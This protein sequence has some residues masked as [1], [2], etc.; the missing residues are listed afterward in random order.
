MKNGI[1]TGALCLFSL[2]I[3]GQVGINTTTPQSTLDV[4]GNMMLRQRATG[5]SLTGLQVLAINQANSEVLQIDPQLLIGGASSGVNNTVYAARK[6]PGSISLLS[7][8]IFPT[9]FRA[10]NFV[11]AD[12]IIGQTSLLSD[13]DNTY[14]IPSTGAYAISYTFKY[15]NGI[16]AAIL[17]NNPGLGIVRTRAGISTLIGNYSFSAANLGLFSMTISEKTLSSIY[18]LQAGDKISLGLTGS[19]NLDQSIM[20]TSLAFFYIY[21]ISN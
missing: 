18:P 11:N 20:L 14:T 17:A 13:L 1:I 6:E 8:G 16:Q 10:V 21:K 12:R 7:L 9:G 5:N 4:N 15:G 2:S 3:F 19:Q